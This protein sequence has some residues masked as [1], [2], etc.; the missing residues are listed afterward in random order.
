MTVETPLRWGILST[1]KIARE[2]LIPAINA[3]PDCRVDAVASR[4]V[5]TAVAFGRD[6][7]IE[8]CYGSYR[9]LLDDP[10]ID[11][12]YNPLPNHLHGPYTLAAARAGKHV[13]CEKPFTMD[14]PEARRLVADLA[15]LETP[16]Q[17]MEGFMYQFHPQWEAV[18]DMIADGRIGRLVAV[19]TWFSY[20]G[21]DP[22]N[23]R[24]IVETGGGALMDIGCYAIHSARR[25]FDDEPVR[26]RGSLDIHPRFG[27]DV[28]ASAVLDFPAGQ[29]T[30]TVSTQSDQDQR[31]HIIGTEGRIEITRPFNAIAER[32]MIVRVGAGMGDT[33]DQPLESLAFGPADQYSIMVERFAAALAA[34]DPAPRSLDDAV[35]NM[36]VIDAVRHSAPLS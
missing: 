14:L 23:I 6:N 3:A 35:A 13:L 34:G 9:E 11:V 28:T 20:F 2:F 26:V 36:A 30:F 15:D 22:A 4:Q 18:F 33:Y 5:E 31:V 29:A 10:D 19:Q 16:V 24:N 27:V 1:A 8:R 12:I 32:P 25:L 17:V 7:G 21:D